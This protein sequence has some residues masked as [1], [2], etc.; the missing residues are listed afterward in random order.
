MIL[1]TFIV[2]NQTEYKFRRENLIKKPTFSRISSIT[3]HNCAVF[4]AR[5]IAIKTFRIGQPKIT[6]RGPVGNWKD[7][8]PRPHTIVRIH[9]PAFVF[10]LIMSFAFRATTARWKFAKQPSTTFKTCPASLEVRDEQTPQDYLRGRNLFRR[11][12]TDLLLNGKSRSYG[13]LNRLG[14]VCAHRYGS[15]LNRTRTNPIIILQR[16]NIFYTNQYGFY[17]W[18]IRQIRMKLIEKTNRNF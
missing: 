16:R 6:L 9:P 15:G 10:C 14:V 5:F 12:P 11:T 3:L 7:S 4:S 17:H 18:K 13:K 1:L 2:K 8:F